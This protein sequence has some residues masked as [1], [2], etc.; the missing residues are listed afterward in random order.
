MNTVDKPRVQ[1]LEVTVVVCDIPGI[2]IQMNQIYLI[3]SD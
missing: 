2:P 3:I 1:K